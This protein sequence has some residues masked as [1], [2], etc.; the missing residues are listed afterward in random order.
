MAGQKTVL[1]GVTFTD[2]TLPILRADG[3]LSA[4]SLYLFDLGHSLGQ[5]TGVPITGTPIPNIAYAEAAVIL[6]GGSAASLAGSFLNNSQAADALFERTS[7]KGLQGIYS[8][9]NN[10]NNSRGAQINLA[11]SIR[12]Y[13]IANKTHLF[14]I[15]VW[16]RRTRTS[17]A[18]HRFMEIGT[19]GSYLG[20]FA[21]TGPAS[22][23]AGSSKIVGGINSVANRFCAMTAQAGAAD[24]VSGAASAMVFGNIG[25]GS[26]LVNQCPSDI[27]YRAYCEDLT[28]SG[29]TYAQVEALDEA[30]WS[31]AFGA[32]GRF[33]DDTFTAAS[34]FP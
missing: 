33:A 10:S 24:T 7:K 16:G 11:T 22:K 23:V 25:S 5:V 34:A 29:R 12:D 21:S 8:Q 14:Y 18:G 4:G 19:G 2:T 17:L 13:M 27:F 3:V 15:S 1:E 31:A 20:Y 9:V 6:G 32:G 26:A 30:L 28:V